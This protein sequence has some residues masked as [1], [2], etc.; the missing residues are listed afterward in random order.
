MN[1]FNNHVAKVKIWATIY[2]WCEQRQT[3]QKVWR[4]SWTVGANIESNFKSYS[5]NILKVQTDNLD[6]VK[7]KLE[8]VKIDIEKSTSNISEVY[9]KWLN[10]FIKLKTKSNEQSHLKSE[11]ENNLK[12][13]EMLIDL[14]EK[15]DV[16]SAK[17]KA[18]QNEI[19]QCNIKN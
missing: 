16:L 15:K 6:D 8:K 1:V 3:N 7:Q 12:S 18:L 4:N 14:L 11:F 17:L 5:W 9:F 13:V 10:K 19:N 2:W